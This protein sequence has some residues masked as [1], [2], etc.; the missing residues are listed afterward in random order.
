MCPVAFFPFCNEIKNPFVM[1]VSNF[2]CFL[3]FRSGMT[4]MGCKCLLLCSAT[5][6]TKHRK[7]GYVRA[8]SL[9]RFWLHGY[10]PLKQRINSR[11]HGTAEYVE[12]RTGCVN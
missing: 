11:A 4:E 10:Q 12:W 2:L 5:V 6:C 3:K 9:S 8:T 1:I 7:R